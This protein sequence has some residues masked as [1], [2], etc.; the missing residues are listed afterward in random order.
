MLMLVW[1]LKG[2]GRGG[3]RLGI[4]QGRDTRSRESSAAH[5]L[6]YLHTYPLT[7]RAQLLDACSLQPITSVLA[8]PTLLAIAAHFPARD[9]GG[10][11]RLID[12]CVLGEL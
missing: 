12:N 1:R 9:K 5:T 4:L 11:V 2:G 3:T 6:H 10:G 8:Q 7:S